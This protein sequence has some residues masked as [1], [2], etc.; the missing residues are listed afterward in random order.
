MDKDIWT[1]CDGLNNITPL[2]E[3]AWRIVEAQDILTTRKLVD[4]AEEQ[5]ILEEMIE[6]TKPSLPKEYF[7]YHP[8]LYT[9]FRLPPL[10]YGSR[11][12]QKFEQSLWYGSRQLNTAMAEKAFYQFSFLR[13][14]KAKYD[15][16]KTLLTAF[17]VQIKTVKGIKLTEPPFSKYTQTISSPINYKASQTLGRSM[18]EADIQAFNYQSA[19][20]PQNGINIAL[21]SPTA[22]SQKNPDVESFQSWLCITNNETI[23]F[24]RSSS[25]TPESQNF[26]IT[27]F[28]IDSLLP[29]PTN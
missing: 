24:I 27:H 8:L 23:D 19:R 17:S 18:R 13:A 22:F 25:M 11:F 10:K 4:S 12:G 3:T 15:D 29:F 5:A 16:V 2:N 9:P 1:K 7:N 28:L 6:S 20:D 21:F 26:H 14:S